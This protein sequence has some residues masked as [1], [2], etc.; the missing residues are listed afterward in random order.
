MLV[1]VV[2]CLPRSSLTQESLLLTQ[3]L[4]AALLDDDIDS[5]ADAEEDDGFGFGF[6]R[7]H[8][9]P[10]AYEDFYSYE[11]DDGGALPPDFSDND[12]YH[13]PPPP[14]ENGEQTPT[15]QARERGQWRVGHEATPWSSGR[16]RGGG[17]GAGGKR[18]G[19][20][21]GSSKRRVKDGPL[22]NLLRRVRHGQE[23]EAARYVR[24]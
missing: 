14:L 15:G 22:V 2:G 4:P 20:G 6:G 9:H 23:G 7:S 12:H 10:R 8:H 3:D 13:E 17:A 16:K 11:D 1:V 21:G 18:D 24:A 5:V 19:G